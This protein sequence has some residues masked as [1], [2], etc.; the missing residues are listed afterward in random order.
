MMLDPADFENPPVPAARMVPFLCLIGAANGALVGGL[1]CLALA[2]RLSLPMT[3]PEMLQLSVSVIAMDALVGLVAAFP[4]ALWAKM[5]EHLPRWLGG[6]LG[7]ARRYQVAYTLGVLTLCT[8]FLVPLARELW[9]TE[10]RSVAVGMVFLVLLVDVTAWFN[11]GYFFRRWLVGAGPAL[12][13]RTVITALGVGLGLVAVA[14][15]EPRRVE[16]SLLGTDNSN[17][18]LVTIDTLRRDHVGIYGSLVSTPTVDA[19][20]RAGLIFDDALTTIPETLPSHAAMLT[21]NQ[22]AR[23]RVL[24]NGDRLSSGFLTVTEQLEAAGYRTGAFVSSFAVDGV[25][26][27]D[28]G[29][30]VYDDDF[31]PSLRGISS[32]R[33]ARVALPLLMRFADPADFPFL[34]ERGSPETVRRALAWVGE[35]KSADA[36]PSFLWVHL[37]DPHAP[38]EPRDGFPVSAEAMAIDH[39]AILAQEPGYLYKPEE[40][41]GL[42]ELYRQECAYADT[43]VKALLDGLTERGFLDRAVVVVVGD[44]GESLGQHNT[45]FNHHGV[46]DDV[47]RVPL[48]VWDSRMGG[49]NGKAADPERG[50]KRF[51]HTVTTAD[52]ANTLLGGSG[53]S[54]LTGTQSSNLLGFVSGDVNTASSVAIQGRD[55]AAL[56]EGQ[57]CGVRSPN[58]KYIRKQ[59]G[60]ELFFD[61]VNDPQ[62]LENIAARE[63]EGTARGRAGTVICAA[64]LVGRAALDQ[65]GAG[66]N[67]DDCARLKA[68]GYADGRCSGSP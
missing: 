57:L 10:R 30:Q 17:V 68:L 13:Y 18:V 25:T 41:T 45:Y 7:L 1:E 3:R 35:A 27:L 49:L 24:S 42:Q 12:G 33:V 53:V 51:D 60:T 63:P 54:V 50:G 21:G 37:F 14:T 47:L 22:P 52:V 32:S 66:P 2:Q 55:G 58:A 44:H 36:R 62:E 38:Y 39:R 8:V 9:L 31:F 59:D 64:G 40:I 20:G 67:D 43:Q 16:Q 11:S 28:Q 26:G 61:L 23:I 34:L 48:V 56:A 15:Q 6:R 4:A 19:L 5:V 46:Y 29:F 65:A